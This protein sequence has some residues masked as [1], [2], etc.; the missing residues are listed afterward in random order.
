M[1]LAMSKTPVPVIPTA[2][3]F[4][5]AEEPVLTEAERISVFPAVAR[6]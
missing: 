5:A 3:L 4:I 6:K 2:A 1:P